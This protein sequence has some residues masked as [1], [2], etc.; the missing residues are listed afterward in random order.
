MCGIFGTINGKK[1]K[2]FRFT[3]FSSLGIINDSRGG[4]SCGIF[5]DK[6]YEYG[7]SDKKLFKNFMLESKLLEETRGQD[8]SVAIGHCR[9][10]SVG[11]VNEA[12]AQPVII[13]DENGDPVFVLIHN[14]TIKN[15]DA[16]AAKYLPETDVTGMTDSQ[17]MARIFF[18][19]GYDVLSE[20]YGG[21]VFFIVDYRS[22][23]P[24]CYFFQGYSKISEYSKELQ[25]ERPF[26]FAYRDG[27]L[28]F[29]SI[30]E[31]L[32]AACPGS[33]L[34]QPAKNTL[35]SYSE[36]GL[37]AEKEY[38]RDAVTQSTPPVKTYTPAVTAPQKTG[39]LSDNI[40]SG[41]Q[42]ANRGSESAYPPYRQ[43]S[44]FPQQ[45]SGGVNTQKT[46][47]TGGTNSTGGTG[48]GGVKRTSLPS[49]PK[50]QK[51][52][53]YE[54]KGKRITYNYATSRYTV[55]NVPLQGVFAV[56]DY[57]TI[58]EVTQ[59]TTLA[60]SAHI[61]W[62]FDGIPLNL[63]KGEYM[64]ARFNEFSKTFK[65]SASMFADTFK[66]VIRW[67]SA[68]RVYRDPKTSLLLISTG[69]KDHMLFTGTFMRICEAYGSKFE[70]GIEIE[71]NV[72]IP[73]GGPNGSFFENENQG[74]NKITTESNIS[75][76]IKRICQETIRRA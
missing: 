15:H 64:Y 36:K 31:M 40:K 59:G 49:I 65:M 63:E 54:L 29:S 8:V 76:S 41:F 46:G 2:K 21:G 45:S 55:D 9:K 23:K 3:A 24:K 5:I 28:V 52:S 33:T 25:Q 58:V 30:Y 38:S 14:G 62:F 56:S 27:T 1:P 13:K 48:T 43:Q 16:L 75:K 6:K 69:P 19:A 66:D 20:Y 47:Q 34:Y 12:N 67:Y 68:D 42:G 32:Q 4:D 61:I 71:H 53:N 37:V 10:A 11:A 17:I 72:L 18:K 50:D 22:G 39:S 35:Y 44:A 7:V 51:L 70:A 73:R 60:T 57:G 74:G 26:Y